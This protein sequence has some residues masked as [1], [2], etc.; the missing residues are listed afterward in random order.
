MSIPQVNRRSFLGA[1]GAA[2]AGGF[3]GAPLG[4]AA[5]RAADPWFKIGLAQWSLHKAFFGKTL[6][7]VPENRPRWKRA[8]G[9][10]EMAMGEA[11]GRLFVE[12]H[13]P[14]EAKARMEGLVRNLIAAYK[15]S[16]EGLDWMRGGLPS[17][18]A[19]IIGLPALP[20]ESSISE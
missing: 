12:K 5:S 1:A 13:F 2:L 20:P 10:V 11:A 3:A 7:G 8:I 16:I 15:Q 9:L 14:P 6:S 19:V 18:G 17:S 4:L